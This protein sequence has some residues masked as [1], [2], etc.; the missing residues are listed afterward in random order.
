[1]KKRKSDPHPNRLSEALEELRF[2]GERT[3]NL[4]ASLP[5]PREAAARVDSWL[6]LQQVQRAGEVLV[7]TGRGNQSPG[8]VSVV[9]SA[10]E[11]QLL[12]LRRLGVV[13]S[14]EENTPGSFIV[15]LAP[16]QAMVDAPARRR[17]HAIQPPAVS[18]A[19]LDAAALRILRGLSERALEALG[20]PVTPSFV[21]AEMAR[22]FTAIVRAVPD[23]PDRDARIQGALEAALAD[24]D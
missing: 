5:S 2:G 14:I 23:G 15:T 21:E 10:V 19:G 11:R 4:R 7:I 17:T 18:I 3:L 16:V 8:G 9:R 12:L 24:M 6:R 20:A 13:A 22:Q 1:M